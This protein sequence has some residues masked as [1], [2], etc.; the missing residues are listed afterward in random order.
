VGQTLFANPSD[1]LQ[2]WKLFL[3][4]YLEQLSLPLTKEVLFAC[5]NS[6]CWR[7]RLSASDDVNDDKTSV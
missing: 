4:S 2:G 5:T 1:R 6:R 3:R 7:L